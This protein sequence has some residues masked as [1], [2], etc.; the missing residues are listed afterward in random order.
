MTRLRA[1]ARLRAVASIAWRSEL[2]SGRLSPSRQG[3]GAHRRSRARVDPCR[4]GG[5]GHCRH[6]P[7]RRHGHSARILSHRCTCWTISAPSKLPSFADYKT[8]LQELVQRQE[9]A[10]AL[11]T[12]LLGEERPG[13]RKDVPHAG[14]SER[15]ARRTPAPA[16][17]KKEAEQAAAAARAGGAAEV[18]PRRRISY[19]IFVPHLQAAR[20]TAFSATRNASPAACFPASAET[21]RAAVSVLGDGQRI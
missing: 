7:R 5:G 14:L 20:M 16:R 2:R 6:V 3:R 17:T 11:P 10:G 12:S 13:S 9:R 19:P 4:R 8:A 21:V 15:R 1:R 18:T